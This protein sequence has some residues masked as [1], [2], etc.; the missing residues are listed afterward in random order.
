MNILQ[1]HGNIAKIGGASQGTKILSEKILEYKGVSFLCYSEKNSILDSVDSSVNKINLNLTTKNVY[2]FLE[3]LYVIYKL[4]ISEKIDIIH[5]HHRNDTIYGCILK[6]LLRDRIALIYTVHGPQVA[7]KEINIFYKLLNHLF[8]FLSNKYIDHIIYISNFTKKKTEQLFKKIKY[9]EVIYNGTSQPKILTKE[10]FINEKFKIHKSLFI[11][12]MAG[13]VSGYK[14]PKKFV[15]I[16]RRLKRYNEILFLL[17]GDGQEKGDLIKY[18]KKHKI[19]N[20]IFIPTTDKIYNYINKSSI[21]VSTAFGEGFG[22]TLIEGMALSKPVIAFNSGGPKEII[23]N[24]LN[25]FLISKNDEKKFDS[26]ILELYKDPLKTKK[27]G[28]ASLDI[29]NKKFSY[30]K[31]LNEH[32]NIFNKYL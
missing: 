6:I 23:I 20:L 7:K 13:G 16:A 17:I 25:G 30:E 3:N 11:V 32:I 26:K 29:Y 22:R 27:F 18:S 14:N 8:L 4:I 31:Y 15:E 21:I 19:D 5:C 12:T 9:Q 2:K 24:D 28:I 1:I 10:N